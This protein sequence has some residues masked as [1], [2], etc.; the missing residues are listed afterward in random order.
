M[1]ITLEL[2]SA[3]AEGFDVLAGRSRVSLVSSI[4]RIARALDAAERIPL[5]LR[6]ASMREAY[7]QASGVFYELD[8]AIKKEVAS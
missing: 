1:N 5:P 2:R 3:S 7:A 6:S 8:A 4:S